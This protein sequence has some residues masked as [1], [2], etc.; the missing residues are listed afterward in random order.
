[1]KSS[2]SS[3]PELTFTTRT[4]EDECL[5]M[6]SDGLWDVVSTEY[7]GNLAYEL[8]RHGRQ[9]TQTSDN[10]TQYIAESLF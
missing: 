9:T 4:E 5:I 8:M 6:A 10:P 3:V 2:V 7:V 1:M